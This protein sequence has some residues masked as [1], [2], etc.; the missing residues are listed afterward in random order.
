MLGKKLSPILVEIERTLW[1]HEAYVKTQVRYTD[2]ALRAGIKIFSSVIL[3]RMYNLQMKENM[4]L[5][6]KKQMASYLANEINKLVKET[7]N[8]NIK[9]LY[10]KIEDDTV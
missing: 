10:D 4:T 3:D 1:N 5:E 6:Q 9:D 2:E 8:I 7:T